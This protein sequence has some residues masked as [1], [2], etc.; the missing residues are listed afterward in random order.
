MK[1]VQVRS[2]R[3]TERSRAKAKL[4]RGRD[5]WREEGDWPVAG[6]RLRVATFG[7][8]RAV[9]HQTTVSRKASYFGAGLRLAEPVRS[10]KQPSAAGIDQ[11]GG[12]ASRAGREL[13]GRGCW[14]GGL[15]CGSRPRR[16][17]LKCRERPR[18]IPGRGSGREE[19]LWQWRAEQGDGD[20]RKEGELARLPS[21]SQPGACRRVAG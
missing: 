3:S 16:L 2:L 18:N 11:R 17:L 13:A 19:T 9:S 5:D 7:P 21:R 14:A 4:G 6:R 8:P 20:G 10:R 15:E 1:S 12:G